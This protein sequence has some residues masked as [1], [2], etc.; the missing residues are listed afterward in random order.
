ML[1]WSRKRAGLTQH[2]LAR[3]TG[4]PQP[5]IAR[6][7]R[8]SV[9]P[10]TAT[11]MELLKATGS[12][13]VVEPAI[14]TEVD[15]AAI[16]ERL[17]MAVPG[18][19]FRAMGRGARPST[20]I[21]RRLRRFGVRFVLIGELAEIAHGVPAPPP[22]AIEV[23]P[24]LD[25]ENLERLA[26]ALADLDA[27]PDNA[28]AQLAGGASAEVDT[29]EGILRIT[30]H[31]TRGEGIDE[32]WPNATKEMVDTSLQVRVAALDDLMRLRRAG[33]D[34]EDRERLELLGAL[35]DELDA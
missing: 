6:I 26:T 14:G 23:C 15:R 19:T 28:A 7:E 5:S 20:R 35:R 21:L 30:P 11:L 18:R 22:E 27:A 32:L 31:P 1:R 25:Q 24:S 2:D 16:R 34:S 9:A 8:G 13:L 10:R 29:R 12:E 17:R 3:A 4:V 33:G